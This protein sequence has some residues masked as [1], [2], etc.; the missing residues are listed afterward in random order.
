MKIILFRKKKRKK[1][2]VNI[3]G[4]YLKANHPCIK[5]Q[6]N[7]GVKKERKKNMACLPQDSLDNNFGEINI[8]LFSS[9]IY[10]Q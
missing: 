8:P 9:I 4:S 5:E 6:E 3:E 10:T 2:N 1:G 7:A